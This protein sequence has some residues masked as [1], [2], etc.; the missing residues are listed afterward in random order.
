MIFNFL[1]FFFKKY[2]TTNKIPTFGPATVPLTIV[3]VTVDRVRRVG[4]VGRKHVYGHPS[5]N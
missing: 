1:Y 4:M 2:I 5:G 3:G